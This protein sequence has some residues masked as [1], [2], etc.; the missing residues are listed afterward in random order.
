MRVASAIPEAAREGIRNW[1][2]DPRMQQVHSYQVRPAI[3]PM[4][5]DELHSPAATYI[6]PISIIR[7]KWVEAT[8]DPFQVRW[9][10]KAV[11]QD[12]DEVVAIGR[13]RLRVRTPAGWVDAL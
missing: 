10:W 11:R 4:T 12:T 9:C 8:E 3:L 5:P 2:D 13:R 1:L 7:S 6:L